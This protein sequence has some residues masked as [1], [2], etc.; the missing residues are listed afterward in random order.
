MGLSYTYVIWNKNKKRYDR[1]ILIFVL[2]YLILFSAL[3]FAFNPEA[4]PETLILRA[5]GTLS[6]LLLH[7]I[8]L[9]G[10]LARLN[11]QFLPLLY[12]RR[13]LGVTMFLAAAVH[14][15]FAIIQFHTLGNINPIWSIFASNPSYGSLAQFPFQTLGFLALLIFFTMAATSHDFFLHNLGP[16]IW[17]A[18][19]MKVYIAYA[20][21]LGHVLLG[22]FQQEASS[23][24]AGLMVLGFIAISTTHIRA[25]FQERRKDAEAQKAN[26]E[27]LRV[28]TP[29]EIE[30]S[31]AKIFTVANER[32]AIFKHE[33]ALS[34]VHNYCKHQ[35]GP[36]GEGKIVDGCITCPWHGYQYLPGNGQ[37]PPPFTEKIA[38]Y[39]LKIED[40]YVYIHAKALA[41]GTPVEPCKVPA[42]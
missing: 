15:I 26:E 13:H 11:P 37:S 33:G 4:T 28:C 17:K 22:A 5:F 3:T 9:I 25:A 32:V 24:T 7:L 39:K 6:L 36:L 38:T 31:R 23:V 30:E 18:L 12:N 35:G 34:A 20:L 42:S 41:E 2:S 40:G 8:L 14:G 1:W 16:R 29:D 21:L 19:H 10:P 27:W